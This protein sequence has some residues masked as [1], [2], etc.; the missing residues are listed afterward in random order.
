MILPV[1]LAA[2]SL[3]AGIGFGGGMATGLGLP[4]EIRINVRP[5]ILPPE[6]ATLTTQLPDLHV[7]VIPHILPPEQS[8]EDV[9]IPDVHVNVIPNIIVPET[10]PLSIPDVVVK[11][12]PE[13]D[14]SRLVGL[15][16][17]MKLFQSLGPLAQQ[18]SPSPV[19]PTLSDTLG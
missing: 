15:E 13:L 5:V 16:D 4:K 12:V 9:K 19:T 2:L 11:I 14:L 8:M 10:K 3:A 7:N 17:L 1:K 18:S 6:G